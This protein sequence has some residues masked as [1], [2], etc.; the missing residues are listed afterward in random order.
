MKL[1]KNGSWNML[2]DVEALILPNDLELAFQ[3][4]LETY[5]FYK[6]LSKTS[7]KNILLSMVMAKQPI[8]RQKRIDAIIE[9]SLQKKKLW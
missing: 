9:A 2:D 8:T 3:N 6:N 1:K 5:Y 4:N 7:K